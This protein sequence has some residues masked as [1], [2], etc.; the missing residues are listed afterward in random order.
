MQGRNPQNFKGIDISS[1]EKNIDLN[2]VKAQGVS[3]VILK[4]SEGEHTKDPAFRDLY[5]KAKAAGLRV[6]AYHFLHVGGDYTVD[7]Q[8]SNFMGAV[9]GLALDCKI[10][11]DIED[12][13]YHGETPEQ[14]TAQVLDFAAK[15]TSKTGI[16][17]VVYS[18]TSFIREHFTAAMKTLPLWVAHYGVNTPGDNGIWDSW[19]GFQYSESGSLGGCKVDLNEFTKE[20]LLNV[21]NSAIPT[22]QNAPVQP[23]FGKFPGSEYFGTGKSN[24]FISKMGERLIAHGY[25]KHYETGAGPKFTDADRQN[26]REWQLALGYKG[27]AADGIP[28]MVSWVRLMSDQKVIPAFP[29]AEFFKTGVTSA[30][31]PIAEAA[32]I[33]AGCN[34]FKSV[35]NPWGAGDVRSYKAF[36][37]KIGDRSL[38]GAPGPWGWAQLQKYM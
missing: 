36:Q 35:G 12:G 38:D 10:A 16:A 31:C 22:S 4:A 6:G 30:F 25:G 33:K 11:V 20:M 17:C 19:A 26:Y 21:Q 18:N 2:A 5:S 9:S 7:K 15:V 3:V 27:A 13:G 1:Y 8:V 28:G 34:F 23:D 32:L 37:R 14:L 29:G 24:S